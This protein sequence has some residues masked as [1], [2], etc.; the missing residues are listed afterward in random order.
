[1]ND[2]KNQYQEYAKRILSI[3]KLFYD[4]GNDPKNLSV[5]EQKQ[6]IGLL[7]ELTKKNLIDLARR[8]ESISFLFNSNYFFVREKDGVE[9]L[10]KHE[11]EQNILT[12]TEAK[13]GTQAYREGLKKRISYFNKL[14][15]KER[16]EIAFMQLYKALSVHLNQ[17]MSECIPYQNLIAEGLE[18]IVKENFYEMTKEGLKIKKH[19]ILSA[20]EVG[21]LDTFSALR[22]LTIIKKLPKERSTQLEEEF[23][24]AKLAYL[25]LDDI[26]VTPKPL[27]CLKQQ[28]GEGY[29]VSYKLPSCTAGEFMNLIHK[30]LKQTI[31]HIRG[32]TKEESYQVMDLIKKRYAETIC[33]VAAEAVA[34]LQINTSKIIE[35]KQE[36][37]PNFDFEFYYRDKI[38]PNL[39]KLNLTLEQEKELFEDLKGENT[40]VTHRDLHPNNIL[41]EEKIFVDAPGKKE[42]WLTSASII[43]FELMSRSS[44]PIFDVVTL[45]ESNYRFKLSK[46]QKIRTL[47]Y[48]AKKIR[49]YGGNLSDEEAERQYRSNAIFANLRLATV[50]SMSIKNSEDT[51]S[52]SYKKEEQLALQTAIELLENKKDKEKNRLEILFEEAE[53][54]CLNAWEYTNS[55]IKN[56]KFSTDPEVKNKEKMKR[57]VNL[58]NEF[59]NNQLKNCQHRNE[60]GSIIKII[61]NSID[62]LGN[63]YNNGLYEDLL[64]V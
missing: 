49:E 25:A 31:K 27:L 64:G 35:E 47:K 51:A 9:R 53:K 52:K 16:Q 2:L 43:D 11:C 45:I 46:E 38:K 7:N 8:A 37:L 24:K 60:L 61:E 40:V 42:Y 39:Q 33:R 10:I 6:I 44:S 34:K 21:K 54:I 30:T 23:R 58:I 63:S 3:E 14:S 13:K 55:V 32:L 56:E 5:P 1:M 12:Q 50:N 57:S 17:P 18:N 48:F 41:I 19:D 28:N 22:E 20:N 36:N 62:L 15:N 4:K 26:N 59:V 29:L